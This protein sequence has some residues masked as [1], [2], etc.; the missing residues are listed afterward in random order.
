MFKKEEFHNVDFIDGY[1]QAINQVSNENVVIEIIDKT[2][3][4]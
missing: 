1:V 3:N 4:E 2:R